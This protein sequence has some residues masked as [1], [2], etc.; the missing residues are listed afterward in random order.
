MDWVEFVHKYSVCEYKLKDQFNMNYEAFGKAIS[1][2]L[3]SHKSNDPTDPKYV[4]PHPAIRPYIFRGCLCGKD[5]MFQDDA[6]INYWAEYGEQSEEDLPNDFDDNSDD[7]S[8]DLDDSF[9]EKC[10]H[11]K[12]LVC[13]IVL[14]TYNEE[15]DFE[16][17]QKILTQMSDLVKAKYNDITT[18]VYTDYTNCSRYYALCVTFSCNSKRKTKEEYPTTVT[19]YYHIERR[20]SGEEQTRGPE[21]G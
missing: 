11:M 4:N 21:H 2:Y 13:R 20:M 1:D 17:Y 8:D 6:V 12:G 16:A 3:L 14:R 19:P 10:G 15:S 9:E 18:Y 5:E 7:H